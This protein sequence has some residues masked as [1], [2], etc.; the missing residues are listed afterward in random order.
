MADYFTP[1][2][3]P[4]TGSDGESSVIRSVFTA[5]AEGFAKIAGYTGN[6]GKIV[7]IN[8]GGTAQE[9]IASTG[10]GDVVRATSPTLVTPALGTPASGIATNMT[11]LPLTTGVTGTLSIANGGTNATTAA[12]ARTSIGAAA[13]A[14][15]STQ[16]FAVKDL[17]ITGTPSS[18][19]ACAAG[20]VR[21]GPNLCMKKSVLTLTQLVADTVTPL[22]N[23]S[24]DSK[25]LIIHASVFAA[26]NNLENNTRYTRIV[27]YG[28]DAGTTN[29]T[30]IQASPREFVA[31]VAG[32]ICGSQ[33]SQVILVKDT[34]YSLLLQR[35]TGNQGVGYY[36]IRGYYD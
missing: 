7:A 27:F 2:G 16:D 34:G 15:L 23:P 17:A 28:D 10:T 35:D 4:S 3:D 33:I 6:G 22:T 9:A 8:A 21:V 32:Q 25:A 5:I 24:S 1:G 14:G 29:Q 26:T 31:T 20:Y 36:E 12:A 11:G 13:L 18:A 30:E 19:K